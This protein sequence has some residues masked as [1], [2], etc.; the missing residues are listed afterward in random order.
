RDEV[1]GG[2]VTEVRVPVEQPGGEE[3]GARREFGES[4][5]DGAGFEGAGAA[6]VD[7]FEFGDLAHGGDDGGTTLGS[8]GPLCPLQGWDDCLPGRPAG[9]GG[10]GALPLVE[11]QADE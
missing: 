6:A 7:E 8:F 9:I 11:H 2:G 3:P 4:A 10:A 1:G 5:L